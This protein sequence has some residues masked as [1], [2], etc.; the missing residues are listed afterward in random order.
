MRKLFYPLALLVLLLSAGAS[1]QEVGRRYWYASGH[2]KY[3]RTEFYREPSFSSASFHVTGTQQF[4]ILGARRG[5]LKLRFTD[6]A[7]QSRE[8][9]IYVRM[10]KSVLYSGSAFTDSL[11]RFHRAAIFEEDPEGIRARMEKPPGAPA[12]NNAQSKSG[13]KLKPWQKYKE[14]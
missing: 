5:W 6:S 9:F 12:W 11:E 4:E 14:K 2:E 1:A 3:E 7:Y 8:G 10:F 13:S